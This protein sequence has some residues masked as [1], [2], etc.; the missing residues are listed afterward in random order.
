MNVLA[1]LLPALR[2]VRSPLVGGYLWLLAAWLLFGGFVPVSPLDSESNTWVLIGRL[3]EPLGV[4]GLTVVG[5]VTAYLVG[6]L[7][8]EILAMPFE[9]LDVEIENL[10]DRMRLSS[11]YEN[12]AP[13]ADVDLKASVESLI[14]LTDPLSRQASEAKFRISTAAPLAVVAVVAKDLGVALMWSGVG[15]SAALFT[16]ALLIRRRLRKR[17]NDARK[18]YK[19]LN[20]SAIQ[21]QH[22]RD[23][24][25][26]S[27]RDAQP[28]P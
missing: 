25:V 18:N 20:D 2:E 6:S 19:R 1:H 17:I 28:R 8:D 12:S 9:D 7:V 11:A 15:M 3:V 27:A 14:E 26:R 5:S 21:R 10:A 24:A 13:D 23:N 4:A 16:H 22:V